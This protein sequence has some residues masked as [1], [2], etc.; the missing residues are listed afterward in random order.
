MYIVDNFIHH[1]FWK[2]ELPVVHTPLY[3]QMHTHGVTQI[4]LI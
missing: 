3:L 4:N 2:N 1:T